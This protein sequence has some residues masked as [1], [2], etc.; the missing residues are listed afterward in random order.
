MWNLGQQRLPQAEPPAT[1]TTT[2]TAG[3]PRLFYGWYIVGVA[4]LAQCISAGTQAFA[5]GLFLTPMT[6]ELGWSRESFSAVQTVSTFVMGGLGLLI[7]G[8]VD[9]RGPRRLMLIGGL[10]SGAALIG[11]S[12]VE[13]LWQFYL[14]RGVAQTAGN[15]LLGN[16][17]VN[18]TVA[19]WF[20]V[21]RGMAVAIASLGIS[22]GGVLVAPLVAL[23]IEGGGWRSAWVVLGVAVW[24]LMLPSALIM[25][26]QPEDF[27]LTPDGM[28]PDQAQRYAQARRRASASS[29]R[30]WTR[31]EALRTS[32]IWLVIFAYGV[33]NIGLGAL[34]LH[35]IPFLTDHGIRRPQ[36]AVLLSV[37]AWA[38]LLSK[39]VWGT[40]MDRLHARF[41]SA[42]AFAISAVSNVGML[43]AVEWD[44][45]PLLVVML[46]GYGFG[47]GGSV[48]LQETVWASYFGRVHLGS[49][50]AV[51][52]P[53]TILFSATGPLL[54]GTLY[55]RTGSYAV[56]FLVFAG[57]SLLGV[58]L[59]L[60]ARP[61]RLQGRDS[62][63]GAET[64]STISQPRTA[65]EKP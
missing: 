22:L 28:T 16:L 63:S 5:S 29:E 18:V 20:V 49:I 2:S 11:T 53:F 32:T 44:A 55:D 25:R 52:M 37:Y 14:L 41:L 7:G 24:V 59:V 51:A 36:A 15:A 19:K 34:L 38:A 56:A 23:V 35:M 50:R 6:E 26:R 54:A 3:R 40:L 65:L 42:I 4:L 48:P 45:Y 9:R 47:T 64:A 27:G 17:V 46:L 21:R 13:T 31:P 39:P 43:A 10:I 1:A 33:A 30:Q 61:P 62:F 58:V 12:R 8:M 57:C 60:L